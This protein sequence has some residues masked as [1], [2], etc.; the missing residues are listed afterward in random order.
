MTKFIYYINPPANRVS[1]TACDHSVYRIELGTAW[2]NGKWKKVCCHCK[3]I[4]DM[5]FSEGD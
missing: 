1:G 2:E 3:A 5:D 4:L